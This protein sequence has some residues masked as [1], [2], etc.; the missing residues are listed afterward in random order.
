MLKTICYISDSK[1]KHSRATFNDL[2]VSIKRNNTTNNITGFLIYK[3]NTFLQ[4]LEGET[5]PVDAVFRHIYTDDR[6]SN[7]FTVI[8]TTIKQRFFEE[9]EFGFT[10]INDKKTLNNLSEYLIWLRAA[11]NIIANRIITMIENFNSRQ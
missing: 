2:T 9:Y 10:L 11:D 4:V 1:I 5:E 8:D 3:N 6:H 7:I